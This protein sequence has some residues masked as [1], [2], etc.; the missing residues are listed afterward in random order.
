MLYEELILKLIEALKWPAVAV[1]ALRM[2]RSAL[3][4]PPGSAS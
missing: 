2:F 1:I 3:A 4:M